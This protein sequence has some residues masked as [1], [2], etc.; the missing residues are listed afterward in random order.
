[1][2]TKNKTEKKT[3]SVKQIRSGIGC[4]KSQFQSLKALGLGKI[5]KVA[6]LSDDKCV[7]GLI[8]KVAHIVEVGEVQ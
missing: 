3:L 1:M 5:G 8:R 6:V 4:E 7:R 2:A